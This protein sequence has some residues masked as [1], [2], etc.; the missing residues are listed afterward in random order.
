ML[1]NILNKASLKIQKIFSKQNFY[2]MFL[3][4]F[5]VLKI[6]IGCQ[7]YNNNNLF[8]LLTDPCYLAYCYLL[9][10]KSS[11]SNEHITERITLT[12]ILNLS[13][14]IRSKNYVP[15][16]STKIYIKKSNGK[17]RPLKIPSPIDKI[18]QKGIFILL[19]EI[20]EPIFTPYSHGY[21]ESYNCHT[22]LHQ[23]YHR[24]PGTK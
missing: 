17:M 11:C 4:L 14:K 22:A 23:I 19:K 12:A 15:N 16:A 24:W 20:F 21:R 3:N 13:V 7:N 18:L 9:L 1:N 2:A 6:Q 10:K 5:F 8:L